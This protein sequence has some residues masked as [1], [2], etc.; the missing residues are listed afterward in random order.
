MKHIR[1]VTWDH[2]AYERLVLD[3]GQKE[4]IRSL[5]D[6]NLSSSQLSGRVGESE[7]NSRAI[8]LLHGSPGTGRT[9]TAEAIA[10]EMERPLLQATFGDMGHSPE[11]R[12]AFLRVIFR[13]SSKWKAGRSQLCEIY[14]LLVSKAESRQVLLLDDCESFL[15]EE[16]RTDVERSYL[17]SIFSTALKSYN[18]K[19]IIRARN[20]KILSKRCQ[21]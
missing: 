9:F 5:F 2:E 8:I 18:G 7:E 16:Y 19:L 10:E 14:D 17:L 12:A 1:H 13:L 20:G 15:V 6:T 4:L 11:Y 3:E 21:P